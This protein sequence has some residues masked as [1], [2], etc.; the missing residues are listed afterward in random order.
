M[1]KQWVK[2]KVESVE[3]DELDIFSVTE[4]VLVKK[5]KI[6]TGAKGGYDFSVINTFNDEIKKSMLTIDAAETSSFDTINESEY[7]SIMNVFMGKEEV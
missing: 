2:E 7:F 3:L 1:L 6:H 4:F 5:I